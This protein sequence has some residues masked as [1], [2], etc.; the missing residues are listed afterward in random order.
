MTDQQTAVNRA[1]EAVQ[2]A[3]V[4]YERYAEFLYRERQQEAVQ[5]Q[6]AMLHHQ[7]ELL[8]E[9]SV[10]LQTIEIMQRMPVS[11]TDIPASSSTPLRSHW[12]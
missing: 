7:S 1:L 8:K 4:R 9:M 11:A 10:R 2:S 5:K 3:T 12:S 6:D